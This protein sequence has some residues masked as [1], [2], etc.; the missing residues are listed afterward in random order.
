MK[1]ITLYRYKRADGGINVSPI[2]PD[3]RHTSAYRL[4][5]DEG[6]A[7]FKD[8]CEPVACIDV[9]STDG[10]CEIILPDSDNE[11]E[12]THE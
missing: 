9:D 12:V 10:W 5:A 6:K 1:I 8:G 4:I 2:K 7:L 11:T 3:S